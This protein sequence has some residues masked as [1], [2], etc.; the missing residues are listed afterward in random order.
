MVLMLNLVFYIPIKTQVKFQ[1]GL[2]SL[3]KTMTLAV[4]LNDKHFAAVESS[5]FENVFVTLAEIEERNEK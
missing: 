5:N 2:L 4:A 3:G 1:K